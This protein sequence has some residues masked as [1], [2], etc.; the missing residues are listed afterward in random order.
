MTTYHNSVARSAPQHQVAGRGWGWIVD[1]WAM[2]K[3]SAGAWVGLFVVWIV[4]QMALNLI[5]FAGVL[6][7]ILGPVFTA[8]I[9]FAARDQERGENVRIG[10]LFAA[11][12]S[13]RFGSL[14]LL[15]LLH[16]V[17]YLL[18]GLLMAGVVFMV[19]G[20]MNIDVE[21]MGMPGPQVL[22][23]GLL[24]LVLLLPLVMA[25]WF[26]SILVALHDASPVEALKL[27]FSAC[28][29][30]MGSLGLFGLIMIPLGLLAA[31]PFFLGFLILAPVAMLAMYRAYIEI[32]RAPGDDQS[33]D[34]A[35][36]QADELGYTRM[37]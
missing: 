3:A 11:F 31:L 1:A 36:K 9:L 27:S 23:G 10:H 5:P 16:L 34:Q 30:N 4:L 20:G 8:G 37:D 6:L 26:S 21:H 7:G 32:F 17:L 13:D 19:L 24:F 14:A 28:M 22:V 2:F 35:D 33:D 18:F 29:Q 25:L 15:G 12:Q